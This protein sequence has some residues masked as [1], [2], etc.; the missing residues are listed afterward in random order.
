MTAVTTLLDRDLLPDSVIRHGIRRRSAQRLLELQTGSVE[1]RHE[2]ERAFVEGLRRSPVAIHTDAANEQ[3]YELPPEF[4]H[5]VLGPRMKYSSAYWPEGVRTLAEAEIA[6]LDLYAERAQLR[7]GQHI[8]ELGCGWGS[9]TL[10][11]A[12]RFPRSQV[13]GVSN[14]APQREWILEQARLRGLDN[15]TIRTADVNTLELDERFD[16][17]VSVEMFEHMKNYE[18]L[19]QKISGWLHEDGHLFVHMFTHRDHSYHFEVQSED[20]WMARHF[21][22]G[23]TM[24]AHHL[25]LEFQNHL[26]VEDHWQLSGV[27]YEKT[28]NAWLSRMDANR[29]EILPMLAGVYG[30]EETRRWWSRWRTFFMA[31]AEMFGYERGEQWLVSHYLL[32]PRVG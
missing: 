17:V 2:R 12:E 3:H 28:A 9:L 16:R 1:Q 14:S 30:D 32:S 5:A 7:D 19:L 13:L 29:D 21:F 22:T 23:G 10:Y 8:L 4:M 24:A 11:M 25:L 6:M 31:C 27:H 20:D 26:V 18:H 15:V